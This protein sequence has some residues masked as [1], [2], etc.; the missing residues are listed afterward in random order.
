MRKPRKRS[1]QSH[2]TCFLSD[3]EVELWYARIAR[4]YEQKNATTRERRGESRYGNDG[5]SQKEGM[6]HDRRAVV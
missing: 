4:L 5:M 1:A 3:R 6:S 2:Q